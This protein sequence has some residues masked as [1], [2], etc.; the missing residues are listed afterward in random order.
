M[1]NVRVVLAV[2]NILRHFGIFYGHMVSLCPFW[3]IFARFGILHQEKSGNPALYLFFL[4][5]P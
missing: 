1:E 5:L 3:Y 2:W 4:L